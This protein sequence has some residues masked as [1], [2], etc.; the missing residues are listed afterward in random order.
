MYNNYYIDNIHSTLFDQPSDISIALKKEPRKRTKFDIDT[1]VELIKHNLEYENLPDNRL[2][3][4]GQVII[5]IFQNAKY[6]SYKAGEYVCKVGE[7]TDYLGFV[8]SGTLAVTV[9]RDGE[10]VYK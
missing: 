4:I 1:I 3:K 5:F 6:A 7:I 10:K 9:P 2:R 8:I